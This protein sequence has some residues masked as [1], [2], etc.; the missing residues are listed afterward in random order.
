MRLRESEARLLHVPV[1]CVWSLL[2][3]FWWG[4]IRNRGFDDSTEKY[5]LYWRHDEQIVEVGESIYGARLT[6]MVKFTLLV[7][8]DSR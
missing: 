3:G 8:L 4:A 1:T 5:E 7:L 6:L 2:C